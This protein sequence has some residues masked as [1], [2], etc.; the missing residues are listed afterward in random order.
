[1]IK[2]KNRAQKMLI[3]P[4]TGFCDRKLN[5]LR[6]TVYHFFRENIL[7]SLPVS[8]F[9]KYFS[10]DNGR[11]TKDIQ[12]MIGLFILQALFDMTDAG[13]IEAYSFNETFRYALDLTRDDCLSERTF[14]YYRAKLLGDGHTVFAKV[15][16]RI[17]EKI[18]LDAHIQ[19][20]DSTL[21]RTWLKRMS[22]MEL[23]RATTK[24]F[25]KELKDR[26][27]I[28]FSRL[29]EEFKEKYLPEKEGQ[30]WFAGDKP[31]QYGERLIEAAKDVLW[32]I[33]QFS[34]HPSVSTLQSFALLERLAK[35][36]IQI[37]D[38][39]IEVKLDEQ[40]KGSALVNPHDPDAR[41]DGHRKAV[42]YHVQLTETCSE[43]KDIDNPKIITQIEVNLANTPDVQTLVPGIEKLEE[44][45]LKP[46]ILLT[47]NGYASDDNH[48]ELKER[49][50]DHV[51]P[52]AGDLHDGFGVMDFTIG[53]D[54]N[55]ISQCPM[56]KPCLENRVNTAKKATT[57]YFDPEVCRSCPHSR[58][59]PVKITK[60][61]A[62]LEWEWK[63]PR[64]EARRL[65]FE[66][67]EETK[68]LFRMRSGGEAT[69]SVLKNPM[70][71]YRIRRRG[72]AKTTLAVLLAAT[73]LNVRRTH[74]WILRKAEEALSKSINR[75]HLSLNPAFRQIL[76]SDRTGIHFRLI[77][78]QTELAMAA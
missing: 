10:S 69:N 14:Y 3:E 66:E 56:G 33:E 67:D 15:L 73:A 23:F 65:Q 31:S 38:E 27:P 24:Q 42:G 18:E 77:H 22:K 71:L 52:P 35:E 75:W 8:V 47:D 20:K 41:Y 48:Q 53:E 72:H 58:D 46:E 11:P 78:G 64:L 36:Q 61:K 19:R 39:V 32:L 21:V 25:L 49:G 40:F 17:V 68:Q 16:E 9:A 59:C 4:V 28:I 7:P 54:G 34:S 30:S 63:R 62:R 5:I 74:Q 43:N 2:Y 13:A 76:G 70:G 44:A 29:P 6:S 26:H 50:V 55:Q 57:S 51:C 37:A 60:R 45:G 1:M 12:S